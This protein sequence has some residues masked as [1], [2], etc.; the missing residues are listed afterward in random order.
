MELDPRVWRIR[1]ECVWKY[2][3]GEGSAGYVRFA[4][5]GLFFEMFVEMDGTW[6]WGGYL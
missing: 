3:G 6:G 2:M 1:D 4:L 5:V